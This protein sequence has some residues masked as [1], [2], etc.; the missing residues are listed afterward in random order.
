MVFVFA[1]LMLLGFISLIITLGT[2]YIAKICIPVSTGD[3]M[4]PCKKVE[5]SDSD[6]DSN[7]RRKLL[8]FDDNVVEWRRV[9]AAASGGDY[10]S[11]KVIKNRSLINSHTNTTPFLN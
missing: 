9:L 4:L 8:S 6:D 7:D 5:V 10:C 1:K 2:Q 11:Q 3:I